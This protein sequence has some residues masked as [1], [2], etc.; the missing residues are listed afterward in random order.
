MMNVDIAGSSE[1]VGSELL[2]V[3]VDDPNEFQISVENGGELVYIECTPAERL[4]G[5]ENFVHGGL[6]SMLLDEAISFAGVSFYGQP[7][8]TAQLEVR[9]R[10]PA[11]TG[12]KLYVRAEPT[13]LS[14]RLVVVKADI[15]LEDGTF[16]ASGTGKVM[17][18]SEE[19]A[20]PYPAIMA[21]FLDRVQDSI[22]PNL[23]V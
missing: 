2:R 12:V 13:K 15:T 3:L 14:K 18:V 19:F 4:Q 1:Y 6:L 20:A 5:W 22:Q 17:P 10:N 11:P 23:H 8:V 9:F 7:A 16:I 21:V